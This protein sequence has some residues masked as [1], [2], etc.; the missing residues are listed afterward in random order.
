VEIHPPRPVASLKEFFREL[1]TITAGILIALSLEGL[2]QW[3][4]HRELAYEAKV[5]IISE[6]RENQHELSGQDQSLRN[7][8]QDVQAITNLVHQLEE[9][10]KTAQ[11]QFRWSWNIAELHSTSW[12][13][14]R[15]TGALSYMP[16]SEVKQ[17]TEC[18]ICSALLRS[19]SKGRWRR[20]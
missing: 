20:R 16:Y 10:K 12:D 9:Q 15:S 5:N 7:M 19:C 6:L 18:M 3:H 8:Q 17:Y 1:L 4:H 14:A 2:I 13:T 11:G